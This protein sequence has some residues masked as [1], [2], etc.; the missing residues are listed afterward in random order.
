MVQW[1]RIR[2]PSAIK[3]NTFEPVL[4]TWTN[5]ELVIQNEASQ[6]EK[7]KF[8]ISMLTYGIYKGDTDEPID[9][10]E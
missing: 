8:R 1:L 9:R 2:L 10:W 5:Q 6:K 7:S 3:R 4:I